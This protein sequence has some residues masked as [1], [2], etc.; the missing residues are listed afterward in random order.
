MS[1][2]CQRVS[3]RTVFLCNRFRSR[4][5]TKARS[6][7]AGRLNNALLAGPGHHLRP[8]KTPG[9]SGRQGRTAAPENAEHRTHPAT[10]CI[11]IIFSAP[12]RQIT[13]FRQ[14]RPA[15]SCLYNYAEGDFV[16]FKAAFWRAYSLVAARIRFSHCRFSN[17]LKRIWSNGQRTAINCKAP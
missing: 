9:A 8:P 7:T 1:P 4:P 2:T 6:A 17:E 5:D 13:Q 10:H 11:T 12:L 14:S 16:G 15:K 3:I